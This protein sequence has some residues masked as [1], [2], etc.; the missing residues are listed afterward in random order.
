VHANGLL[1]SYQSEIE[2]ATIK[3]VGPDQGIRER[4][5][6][7]RD[8]KYFTINGSI[9]NFNGSINKRDGQSNC[10]IMRILIL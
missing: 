5:S 6:E 3:F 10:T 9:T 8:A 2:Y 7:K 1:M 4:L